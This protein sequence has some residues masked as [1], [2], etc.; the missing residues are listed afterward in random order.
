MVANLLTTP[1]LV[2]SPFI[3]AKIGKYTFGSY[4]RKDIGSGLSL[5]SKV[6]YPNF[7]NS[8]EIT[9]VNGTVNTYVIQMV[10]A[11]TKG[12]DPNL[13]E[14]VFS[15]VSRSRKITLSYGDWNSPSFIYREEEAI[16][17]RVQSNV[18]MSGS[19]ITYTINCTSTSLALKA[20]NFNFE[21]RSAKPSD[22]IKE[23][24]RNKS[25]GLSDIFY[26]M[27]DS[28]VV[29]RLGLIPGNDKK[30]KIEAKQSI[31][32][33]DYLNFLVKCMV[34]STNTGENDLYDSHYFLTVVDTKTGELDGPYFR[35]TEIVSNATNTVSDNI[36]TFE[37]DIGYADAEQPLQNLV[38]SFTINSNETWSILYDYNNSLDFSNYTYRIDNSGKMETVYTPNNM[39]NRSLQYA[40]EAEKNWWTNMISFPISA[41]LTIK[42]L[43]RPAI[44]MSYV[45]VNVWFYGQLHISSGLYFI[46]KQQDKIDSQG[47]RTTLTLTRIPSPVE[48]SMYAQSYQSS[49]GATFS[50]GGRRF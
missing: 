34:S 13:L 21:A 23:L 18:D 4:S 33:L 30:V 20:G 27:H 40:T 36:N 46:T 17:T 41:T 48:T 45:K 28:D 2:E 14:K 5:S 38:T 47:Y 39:I 15:S 7:M 50:G 29:K 31:N 1:T 12:D 22:V 11:I 42:G 10:Y 35:I 44:L 16:I 37:I 6:T 25:Y 32:I 49:G 43:I 3:I 26:G 19:K 9:K 8:I 24:L